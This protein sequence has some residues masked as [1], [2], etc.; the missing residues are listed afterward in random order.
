MLLLRASMLH[1]LSQIGEK[2]RNGEQLKRGARARKV[3]Q[4]WAIS[5]WKSDHSG[6]GQ[7][8]AAGLN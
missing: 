4:M 7:I 5:H 8:K 2:K 1:M 6:R 3:R